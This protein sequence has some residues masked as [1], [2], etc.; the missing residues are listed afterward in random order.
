[1]KSFELNIVNKTSIPN[2]RKKIETAFST[3]SGGSYDHDK[4]RDVF[5][6]LAQSKEQIFSTI[7]SL[8]PKYTLYKYNE[9]HELK[10]V[11][12]NTLLCIL[13]DKEPTNI[14]LNNDFPD[15]LNNGLNDG[16]VQK[17]RNFPFKNDIWQP[18]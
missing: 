12:P 4:K 5:D 11:Q 13:S 18:A 3:M 1:M 2:L 16:L 8:F 14:N 9:K 17:V 7:K 10:G 15:V 6:V